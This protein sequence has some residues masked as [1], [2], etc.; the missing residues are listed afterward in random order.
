MIP[1][2]CVSSLLTPSDDAASIVKSVAS[3]LNPLIL[4]PEIVSPNGKIEIYLP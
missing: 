2:S 4:S 3:Y 1:A